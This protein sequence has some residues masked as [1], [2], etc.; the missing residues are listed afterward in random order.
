MSGYQL[1]NRSMHFI[2]NTI[3]G[4]KEKRMNKNIRLSFLILARPLFISS[5]D[6]FI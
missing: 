2:I 1:L 3:I 5:F 6:G 4:K